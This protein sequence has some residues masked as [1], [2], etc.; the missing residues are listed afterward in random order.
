[1]T[2]ET[3]QEA[4]YQKL[5]KMYLD[6]QKHVRYYTGGLDLNKGTEMTVLL[7]QAYNP[8][9]P[10]ISWWIAEFKKLDPTGTNFPLGITA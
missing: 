5:N 3:A 2:T 10:M 9:D 7:L 1:M 4:A 8:D 6:T